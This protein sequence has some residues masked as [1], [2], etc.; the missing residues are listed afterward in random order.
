MSTPDRLLTRQEVEAMVG[1]KRSAIYRW[2]AQGTFP[3]PLKL[4]TSSVR[5]RQS[6]IE[7]WIGALP[8]KKSSAA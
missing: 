8:V 6:E 5:W 3:M 2:M 7:A 4:G 1:V